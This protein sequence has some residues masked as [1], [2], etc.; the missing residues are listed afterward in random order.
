MAVAFVAQW[1]IRFCDLF[2]GYMLGTP[3]V[4]VLLMAWITIVLV[5]HPQPRP[6]TP[7]FMQNCVV[8]GLIFGSAVGFRMETDRRAGRGLFGFGVTPEEESLAHRGS[9]DMPLQFLVART[10]IGYL[11]VIS[12]RVIFKAFFTRCI[13]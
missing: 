7:T 11:L 9:N 4:G 8:C 3:H 13:Q 2:D 5:L 10:V 12:A 1:P 6:M